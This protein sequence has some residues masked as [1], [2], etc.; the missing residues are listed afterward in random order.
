M[1]YY[2]LKIKPKF[3]QKNDRLKYIGDLSKGKIYKAL[4]AQ[5]SIFY[6]NTPMGS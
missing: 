4:P 2:T 6:I 1:C 5:A 3:G